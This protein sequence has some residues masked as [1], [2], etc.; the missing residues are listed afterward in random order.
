MRGSGLSLITTEWVTLKRSNTEATRGDEEHSHCHVTRAAASNMEHR[1]SLTSIKTLGTDYIFKNMPQFP[2][3]WNSSENY[4]QQVFSARI[5]T[6]VHYKRMSGLETFEHRSHAWRRGS[7]L[8]AIR[9]SNCSEQVTSLQMDTNY[10][11]PP[12][13]N[14]APVGGNSSENY[15]IP[16]LFCAGRALVHTNTNE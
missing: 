16:S 15:R 8:T 2:V 3:D 13:E 12:F 10:A 11:F 14:S 5:Q 1:F 6:F 4:K 7:T 9:P